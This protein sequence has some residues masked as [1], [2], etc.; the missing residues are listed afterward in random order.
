MGRLHLLIIRTSGKI[1]QLFDVGSPE[2][3]EAATGRIVVTWPDIQRV[4]PDEPEH[5]LRILLNAKL[6]EV[7]I[8]LRCNNCGGREVY[9]FSDLRTPMPCKR[10]QLTFAPP[11]YDPR[12]MEN[13]AYRLLPPFDNQTARRALLGMT[14]AFSIL[15]DSPGDKTIAAGIGLPDPGSN[16]VDIEVDFIALQKPAY[17]R[18]EVVPLFLEVKYGQ[19]FTRLDVARMAFLLRVFPYG[20][21]GFA[22]TR[23]VTE[24]EPHVLRRLRRFSQLRQG[25]REPTHTTMLLTQRELRASFE[26][27]EAG[28]H[29]VGYFREIGLET[30]KRYFTSAP[31]SYVQWRTARDEAAKMKREQ[32]VTKLAATARAI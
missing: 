13:W 27:V 4:V 2:R 12:S 3:D 8:M 32:R 21:F 16:Q 11:F 23:P 14:F 18:P 20:V 9:L 7:G 29:I 28:D 6:L 25:R 31:P 24:I 26:L 17:D 30:M 10:C 1:L 5:S 15:D 22:T 19:S